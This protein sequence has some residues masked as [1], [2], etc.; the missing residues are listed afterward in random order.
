MG[1]VTNPGIINIGMMPTDTATLLLQ[2][3]DLGHRA[4]GGQAPS[5]NDLVF[6]LIKTFN[7][8]GT[9]QLTYVGDVMASIYGDV[10][11]AGIFESMDHTVN[12]DTN[13]DELWTNTV[14]WLNNFDFLKYVSGAIVK[15]PGEVFVSIG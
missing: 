4:I 14:L 7:L 9:P 8:L 1:Q 2:V 13:I 6:N 12:A 10:S 3:K 5:I 15:E 11:Y